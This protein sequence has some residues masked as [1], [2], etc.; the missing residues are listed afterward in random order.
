MAAEAEAP[1]PPVPF[2]STYV[3]L[4]LLCMISLLF[5]CATTHGKDRQTERRGESRYRGHAHTLRR[6]L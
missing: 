3:Y 1:L 5:T 2:V 6:G 4:A